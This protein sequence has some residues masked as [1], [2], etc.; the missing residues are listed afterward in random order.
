MVLRWSWG[1]QFASSFIPLLYFSPPQPRLETI[2]CSHWSE[3]WKGLLNLWNHLKHTKVLR[4]YY[5]S[6]LHLTISIWPIKW[7]ELFQCLQNSYIQPWVRQ[8]SLKICPNLNWHSGVIPWRN[9][10]KSVQAIWLSYTPVTNFSLMC[11]GR[12]SWTSGLS[13][14]KVY[15]TEN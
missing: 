2:V 12:F 4:T 9:F 10:S 15:K 1:G 14:S 13:F 6:L 11:M 7:S 3:C 8:V 5:C